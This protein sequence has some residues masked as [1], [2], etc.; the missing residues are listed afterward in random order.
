MRG[1]ENQ[2]QC[3]L[4]S[5]LTSYKACY[6]IYEHASLR[7]TQSFRL[8]M[9]SL[10]YFRKLAGQRNIFVMKARRTI[11][12]SIVVLACTRTSTST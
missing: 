9:Y 11:A 1:K 8:S 7:N 6:A 12:N 5:L 10:V 2:E 3:W 4:L